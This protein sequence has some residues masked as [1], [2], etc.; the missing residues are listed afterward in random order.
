MARVV[1]HK[2]YIHYTAKARL[3]G[4]HFVADSLASVKNWRSRLRS[5]RIEWNNA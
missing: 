1:R 3:A 2:P 4:L 5:W